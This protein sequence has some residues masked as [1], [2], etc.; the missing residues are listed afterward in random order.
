ML[1]P[2]SGDA[3]VSQRVTDIVVS[4]FWLWTYS[5]LFLLPV[6]GYAAV[7][8]MVETKSV[9]DVSGAAAYVDQTMMMGVVVAA[10]TVFAVFGL[11]MLNATVGTETVDAAQE[12]AEDVTTDDDAEADE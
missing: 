11:A 4:A 5:L 9:P 1:K 2:S 6:A 10:A 12:Q 3:V 8:I 7:Y